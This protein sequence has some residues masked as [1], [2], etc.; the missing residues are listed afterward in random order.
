MPNAEEWFKKVGPKLQGQ[1]RK[2]R[3]PC[4]RLDPLKASP[5]AKLPAHERWSFMKFRGRNTSYLGQQQ[6]QVFAFQ[7]ADE[8]IVLA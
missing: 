3:P 8:T 2:T 7:V 6:F 4:G 1:G 5:Q